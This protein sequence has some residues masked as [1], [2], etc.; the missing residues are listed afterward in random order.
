[1]SKRVHNRKGQR[2]VSS[3]RPGYWE[4]KAHAGRAGTA[5]GLSIA[6]ISAMIGTPPESPRQRYAERRTPEIARNLPKKPGFVA[7]L[8]R[9]VRRVFSA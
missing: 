5:P 2:R 6:E 9:L 4:R 8:S 7:G 3:A 1:M